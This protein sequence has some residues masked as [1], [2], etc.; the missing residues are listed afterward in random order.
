[1]ADPVQ[2]RLAAI[3][4][5]DVAGYSRLMG[6]DEEGTLATLTAHLAEHLAVHALGQRLHAV[7]GLGDSAGEVSVEVR[8]VG[9][10]DEHVFA[11]EIDERRQRSMP[12]R[13]PPS[14]ARNS[15]TTW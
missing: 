9:G 6:E 14:S 5:T 8:E 11:D 3:L 4:A 2:R 15:S 7:H 10:P 13:S 1:M 12:P